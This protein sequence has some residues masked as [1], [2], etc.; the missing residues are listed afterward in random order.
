MTARPDTRGGSVLTLKQSRN[1]HLE[2]VAG[3]L[4]KH[5]PITD[6]TK[7]SNRRPIKWL[8]FTVA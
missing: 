1:D 5:E 4:L 8:L 3:V 6:N 2:A 7:L